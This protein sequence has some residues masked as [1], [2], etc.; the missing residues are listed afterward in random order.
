MDFKDDL[1]YIIYNLVHITKIH[2]YFTLSANG[3]P[4]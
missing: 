2:L 4:N 3:I 1:Q